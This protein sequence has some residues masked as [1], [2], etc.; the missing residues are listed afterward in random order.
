MRKHGD[1]Q[2]NN[3]VYDNGERDV[4]RYFFMQKKYLKN[5]I[6][7]AR[8]VRLSNRTK[9][10]RKPS[11]KNQKKFITKMKFV[12]LSNGEKRGEQNGEK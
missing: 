10:K 2:I 1:N 11:E 3:M 6:T 4:L 7:K 12:R 9:E 5:F 8:L